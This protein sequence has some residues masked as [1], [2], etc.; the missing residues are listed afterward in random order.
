MEG[1]GRNTLGE[2]LAG[3]WGLRR[4]VRVRLYE[5]VVFT[6]YLVAPCLEAH[7]WWSALPALMGE[8]ASGPQIV[9]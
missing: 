6:V 2:A 9:R 5:P 1:G 7:G 3:C 8:A 4:E